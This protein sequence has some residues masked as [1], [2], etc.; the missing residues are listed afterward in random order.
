MKKVFILLLLFLCSCR[1]EE[2]AKLTVNAKN[3]PCK[4]TRV[5]D[6]DTFRCRIDAEEITVRLIGVDTPES[7]EN[8][9]A[10]RDA[11][12]TGMSLEEITRMGREAYQFTKSLIPV[13]T[14]VYL[15]TDVQLTDRYGRVLAYVWLP[16]GRMLNEVLLKEGYAQVYTIPPNVKYQDLFLSAQRKAR[17]GKRGFWKQWF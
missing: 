6:G 5:V 16:D 14:T 4:I 11:D 7:K 2:G 3:V 10:K 12:R 13:G 17:E 1:S 9:K 8:P 15:E